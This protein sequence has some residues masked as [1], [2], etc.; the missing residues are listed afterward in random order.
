MQPIT[1]DH[2]MD[3]TNNLYQYGTK[4]TKYFLNKY[5]HNFFAKNKKNP[6]DQDDVD[7]ESMITD[8][9]FFVDALFN[10]L[11]SHVKV[12]FCS[13]FCYFMQFCLF[14]FFCVFKLIA[15]NFKLVKIVH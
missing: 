13:S 2:F 7:L 9:D 1:S 14:V 4:V 11:G 5:I 12:T 10:S 8:A 6:F 15:S 3:I